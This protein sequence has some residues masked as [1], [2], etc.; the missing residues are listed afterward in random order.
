MCVDINTIGEKDKRLLLTLARNAIE[1]FA[2]YGEKYSPSEFELSDMM[3]EK[4]GVF[5]SLF[6]AG[7]LRGCIGY[8]EPIKE[9]WNAVIDN[10]IN[11][12]FYDPRFPPLKES[13]LSSLSIEISILSDIKKLDYTDSSDLLSKIN[14]RMGLLIRK[15]M[16]SATYLPEV[17]EQFEDKDDLLESLCLK[18]SLHV[19]AWRTG[20]IDMGYY[21]TNTFKNN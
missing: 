7:K 2:K 18:A 21:Y 17:W 10:S 8:T 11:A 13:E 4:S 12:S 9:I 19:D 20:H 15:G 14:R 6:R 5:V 16:H 1:W 3:Y